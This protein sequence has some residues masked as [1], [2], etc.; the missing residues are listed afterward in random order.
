M[1]GLGRTWKRLPSACF[2]V[3][4]GSKSTHGLKEEDKEITRCHKNSY[5]TASSRKGGISYV[6]MGDGVT[7]TN[8]RHS[9]RP[10]PSQF[11]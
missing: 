7:A 5:N 4:A 9:I 6:H 10:L 11:L 3:P 1:S 8:I 2:A